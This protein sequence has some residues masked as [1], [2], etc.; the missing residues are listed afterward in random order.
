VAE[1]EPLHGGPRALLDVPV[2]PDGGVH[3]GCVELDR[4]PQMRNSRSHR[5]QQRRPQSTGR[6]GATE[7]N[8]AMDG[9]Q[10]PAPEDAAADLGPLGRMELSIL[11]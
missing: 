1:A 6:D 9:R 3:L 8:P 7:G 2:V 5:R 4:Q 10:P 11:P